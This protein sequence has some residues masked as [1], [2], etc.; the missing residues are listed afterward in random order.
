MLPWL[1]DSY[2]QLAALHQQHSLSHALLLSGNQGL[3][4][5]LLAAEL[6]QLLLCQSETLQ[7]PC[8]QCKACQLY[9]AGHHPDFWQE[10]DSEGRIGVDTVRQLS[11]FFHEHAQQGGA[12]VAVLPKAER[13]TEAAANALLKTLEE[14][15]Q[16]AYL[17]LTSHQ[18]ALLLPT[19]LSRCQQWPLAVRQ[20][21]QAIGWLQQ[22]SKQPIP[23][24]LK[25]MSVTAPLQALDWL[26]HGQAEQAAETLL[27]LERYVQ[28]KADM[29]ATV[30]LLLKNPHLPL[31]LSWFIAERVPELMDYLPQRYWQLLQSF[32]RWCRDEQQLLG[33]NKSLSLTALLIELK[34][35]KA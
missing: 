24:L 2:Q 19:I 9:Q 4:K 29:I 32:Q 20:P 23:A 5:H 13:M 8:G 26:Q 28:D 22:H 33:Q 18:P 15:P 17:I 11:R 12:R 35:I 1:E 34:R 10:T 7:K 25:S 30:Q 31:L 3:G 21:E 27:Q 16:H 14:P 6:V